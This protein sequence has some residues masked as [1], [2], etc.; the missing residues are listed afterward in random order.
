MSARNNVTTLAA[1]KLGIFSLTSI[2]VTGLLAVIMGNIGLGSQTSYA[3]VFTT[4]SMLQEGDDVRIAGI[5]VGQ[6]NDVDIVQR[7]RARVEFEIESD[8]VLTGSSRAEIRY[9]NIVGDR[10]LALEKGPDDGERLE[11]E[12][13]IPASR[14]SPALNLT[15]LYN[16]F[17]PLF[18]ALEP[19]Q[20]NELSMNIVQVLQGEG[21][22]VKSLLSRTASLTNSL[23]DRDKLIG[24][25]IDNLDTMLRTVDQR[26]GRLNQ[27][28][29]EMRRWMG[30]LARDRGTIGGSVQ[31]VSTLT[32]QLADLLTRGRPLV[33]EDVAQLRRLSGLLA[34][35]ESQQ[36]LTELLDRLPEAMSDQTRVGTYGS[37]YSYYLCDFSGEIT[38]PR[39]EGLDL[40][41][42]D[43]LTDRVRDRL[44]RQLSDLKF[45]STAARCE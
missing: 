14:T 25:V 45:Y 31:S 23:A 39:L 12:G 3:A 10:Y 36:V 33:K 34:R 38:L 5:R 2:L 32:E 8:V 4:A 35:K 37:W 30:N 9:L 13:T 40:P 16:G 17:Q 21:G 27:L 11:S 19:D 44:E 29:V 1:I 7:S 6:V 41:V 22:T 15:E 43:Q 26:R 18:A 20:I 28:V 42:L 24:E